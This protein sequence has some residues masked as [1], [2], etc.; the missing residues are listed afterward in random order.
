M[1]VPQAL[2]ELELVANHVEANQ[3]ESS[4]KESHKHLAN[5]DRPANGAP[6]RE[7]R[8]AVQAKR[9][10]LQ[11]RPAKANET[12]EAAKALPILASS[13]KSQ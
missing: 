7:G 9:L 2:R 13:R 12:L 11:Y 5:R 1:G 3:V 6:S 8:E 4:P 10:H